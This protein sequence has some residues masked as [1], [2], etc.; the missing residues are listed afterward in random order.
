MLS[1]FSFLAKYAF[2]AS[3]TLR[4]V[5]NRGSLMPPG[6]FRSWTRKRLEAGSRPRLNGENDE[7]RYPVPAYSFGMLGMQTY[8]GRLL[9]GPY[10]WDTTLP[11]LGYCSAGLG[12]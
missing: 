11:M 8:G 10:S 4:R 5:A 7:L 3:S 1:L 6:R 2:T 12:R 9:R